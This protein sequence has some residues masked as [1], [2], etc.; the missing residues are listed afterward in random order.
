VRAVGAFL[1]SGRS[2]RRLAAGL[3]LAISPSFGAELRIVGSDL[4][5]SEFTRALYEYAGRTAQKVTLALDGSRP[6]LEQLKANRAEVGLVVLPPNDTPAVAGF[7]TEPIGYHAL[8]VIVSNS[9]PLDQ[10]TFEQLARVL[11]AATGGGGNLGARWSDLGVSGDWAREAVTPLVPEVGAG[12]TGITLDYLRHVVLRDG[13]V[14]RDMARYARASALA[15]EI[16]A[17]PHTLAIA[18][19]L[20]ADVKHLKALKVST[21]AGHA[22]EFATPETLHRG[23]YPLRLPVHFVYRAERRTDVLRLAEFLFGEVAARAL[24]QADIVPLPAAARAEQLRRIQLKEKP[25]N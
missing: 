13:P 1:F 6:G 22:A 10:I 4:L 24:A 19:Q 16:L 25:S 9:C 14:R 21:K 23:D 2:R 17:D 3:L 5:G 11:G 18:A 15:A 7:E 20:P 12:I 8:V